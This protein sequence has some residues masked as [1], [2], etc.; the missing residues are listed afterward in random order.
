MK[1]KL[2]PIA[3]LSVSAM[4]LA[5]CE[6]VDANLQE[7]VRNSLNQPTQPPEPL[8]EPVKFEAMPFEPQTDRSPFSLPKPENIVVQHS[9][10]KSSD[11]L[12][13]D[14][15]RPKDLLE[16][17][18]LDN[19]SMRG[20]FRDGAGK[21]WALIN[22][23]GSG[24]NIEHQKVSVGNYIGLNYGKITA[25][26]PNAIEIEE[27]IGKGDGCYELKPTQL[28]LSVSSSYDK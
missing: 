28:E 9:S 20:T 18:S 17:F 7:Y 5:G 21:L 14:T 26:T 24:S 27:Y 25:I 2:L 19:L 12:Q 15:T 8:P 3:I 6:A 10:K 22:T 1:A 23:G 16:Q 11:C 13:P 4:M